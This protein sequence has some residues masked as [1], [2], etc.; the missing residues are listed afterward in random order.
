MRILGQTK[1]IKRAGHRKALR[2]NNIYR[3]LKQTVKRRKHL[4]NIPAVQGYVK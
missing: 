3:I 4:R 1:R 2:N